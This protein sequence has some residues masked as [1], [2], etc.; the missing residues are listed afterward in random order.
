MLGSV[1]KEAESTDLYA[2]AVSS[3]YF[4]AL[5]LIFVGLFLCVG[6]AMLWGGGS[7]NGRFEISF[8]TGVEAGVVLE[9][10]GGAVG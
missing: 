7:S 4:A 8:E 5:L 10:K 2:F 6:G 3:P 9:L 1:W